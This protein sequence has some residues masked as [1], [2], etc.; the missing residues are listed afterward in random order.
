MGS[1]TNMHFCSI[2][3]I[4]NTIKVS[5]NRTS[6]ERCFHVVVNAKLVPLLVKIAAEENGDGMIIQA[7]ASSC[8]TI[9]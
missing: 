4:I 9:I 1:Q 3:I 6:D 2:I 5:A 7:M 8:I